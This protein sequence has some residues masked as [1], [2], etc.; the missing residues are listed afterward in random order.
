MR[1]IET[2]TE[3]T[4]YNVTVTLVARDARQAYSFLCRALGE[5]GAE[6]ET[7]TYSEGEGEHS[8]ADL[9]PEQP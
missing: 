4:F 2:Q 8:T 6:W 1:P 3:V 7:D 9:F 5:V